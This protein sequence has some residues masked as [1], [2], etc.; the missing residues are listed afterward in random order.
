MVL[1]AVAAAASSVGPSR[2]KA[3]AFTSRPSA[4]A[5]A[6]KVPTGAI[7]RRTVHTLKPAATTVIS[8]KA[9]KK[10]PDCQGRGVGTLIFIL[11]HVPLPKAKPITN[12]SL[13]GPPRMAISLGRW[14]CGIGT[15][16]MS[17]RN[18][19]CNGAGLN[20][21]L[22]TGGSRSSQADTASTCSAACRAAARCSGGVRYI[23]R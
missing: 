23:A 1:K 22:L 16:S 3:G 6:A 19:R 5:A 9:A 15:S 12:T 13:L 20:R 7:I 14:D 2:A 10:L 8:R 11:S 21:R 4:S 18:W 17:A